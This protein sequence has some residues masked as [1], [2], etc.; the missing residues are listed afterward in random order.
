MVMGII[1]VSSLDK[2]VKWKLTNQQKL[3]VKSIKIGNFVQEFLSQD[4]FIIC[5][6]F[7]YHTNLMHTHIVL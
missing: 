2:K 1:Q 4:K 5:S 6:L 3:K 7:A